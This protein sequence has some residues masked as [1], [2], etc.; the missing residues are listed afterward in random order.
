LRYDLNEKKIKSDI[1]ECDLSNLLYVKCELE[2][3]AIWSNG[4]PI[5]TKDIVSTF[6]L[7]KNGD[8]NPLMAKLLVDTTIEE[9]DNAI[10]FSN[11]TK[12]VAFIDVFFAPII[13][14]S[15]V[16]KI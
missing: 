13:P 10:I 4:D 6:K 7:Y 15:T 3:S 5:T 9:K 14:L 12:N 8:I 1:V 11:P 16:N 2:G